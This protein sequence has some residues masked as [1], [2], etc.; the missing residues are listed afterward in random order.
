MREKYLAAPAERIS[1]KARFSRSAHA[2]SDIDKRVQGS[3]VA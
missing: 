2:A 3:E 1:A